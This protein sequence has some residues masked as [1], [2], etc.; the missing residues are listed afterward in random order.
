MDEVYVFIRGRKSVLQQAAEA[1]AIQRLKI[2][3][4]WKAL[5]DENNNKQLYA[6]RRVNRE[7]WRKKEELEDK[8]WSIFEESI[9]W[10]E[11]NH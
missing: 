2:E 3:D 4:H 9:R 1:D 8:N 11:A 10:G 7:N 6:K 5:E